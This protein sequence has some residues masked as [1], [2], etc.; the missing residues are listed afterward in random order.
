MSL[1]LSGDGTITGINASA[2]GIA[3]LSGATF[4][5]EVDV[6]SATA[7][8]SNSVRQITISTSSP[9]G[10]NDGDVWLVYV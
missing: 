10:G 6:V 8:G 3:S 7:A 4:T 2:T 9:T 1:S 5:G